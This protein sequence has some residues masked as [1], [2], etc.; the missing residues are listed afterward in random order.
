[1]IL[2]LNLVLFRN[3]KKECPLLTSVVLSSF[4]ICVN[5]TVKGQTC[6]GKSWKSLLNTS[7]QNC[8]ATRIHLKMSYTSANLST[9]FSKPATCHSTPSCNISAGHN[10]AVLVFK[11]VFWLLSLVSIM[12]GRHCLLCCHGRVNTSH[13]AN[14]CFCHVFRKLLLDVFISNNLLRENHRPYC[15]YMLTPAN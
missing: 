5:S 9:T 3:T 12:L 10:W 2:Y 8:R 15:S 6:G 1:M 7:S 11:Q 4:G 14:R 13:L